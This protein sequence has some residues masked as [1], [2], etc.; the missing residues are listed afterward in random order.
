MEKRNQDKKNQ[1]KFQPQ[2]VAVVVAIIITTNNKN[3]K[4][5]KEEGMEMAQQ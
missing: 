5:E 1:S 3:S 4:E 2:V